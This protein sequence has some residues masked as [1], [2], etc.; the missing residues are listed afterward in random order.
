MSNRKKS[1]FDLYKQ[2]VYT[3]E[4][5]YIYKFVNIH[6]NSICLPTFPKTSCIAWKETVKIQI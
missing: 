2:I 3:V 6:I 4:Y 5:T 1:Y